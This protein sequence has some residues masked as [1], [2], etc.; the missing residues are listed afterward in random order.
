MLR[1]DIEACIGCGV[2]EEEC[3]FDAI[4]VIDGI[5]V[6]KQISAQH[7]M[8][9]PG[10]GEPKEFHS[11][12]LEFPDERDIVVFTSEDRNETLAVRDLIKNFIGGPVAQTD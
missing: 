10:F 1:I 11:V 6:V 3:T 9:I 4:E 12:V 8:A 5:A 2:C 7:G